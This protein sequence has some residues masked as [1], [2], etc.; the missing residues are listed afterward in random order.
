[1]KSIEVGSVKTGDLCVTKRG[2]VR[3]NKAISKRKRN[4]SIHK[5]SWKRKRRWREKKR[6]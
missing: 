6:V 1:M 2:K 3:F 5:E 4:E